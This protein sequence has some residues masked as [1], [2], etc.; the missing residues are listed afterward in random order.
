VVVHI[1]TAAWESRTS[2]CGEAM[3]YHT[4]HRL[5]TS[6]HSLKNG[7]G[8]RTG[9]AFGSRFTGWTAGSNRFDVGFL[10]VK[11]IFFS[12]NFFSI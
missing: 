10:V 11:I 12:Y 2:L 6:K 1:N 3:K 8:D 9:E 7:I 4:F 5:G